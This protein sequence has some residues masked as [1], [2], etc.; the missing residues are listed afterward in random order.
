MVSNSLTN[1]K[2][3]GKELIS[4]IIPIYNSAPF[5]KR[6]INSILLQ[7]FKD[8]ELILV[9]DGSTDNSCDICNEFASLDKRIKVF[10]RKNE[11]AGAARKF[12][13]SQAKGNWIMFCDSDDILPAISIESLYKQHDKADIIVGTLEIIDNKKRIFNHQIDGIVTSK[14][15]IDALLLN[16]TSIGPVGKLFRRDLFSLEIWNDDK[17]IKN[18]EDLLMLIVFSLKAENIFIDNSKICYTYLLRNDS[19]RTN[20]SPV[21]VWYKLFSN[22]ENLLLR[23]FQSAPVSFYL[24][25]LHRL[26]DCAILKGNTVN[27]KHERVQ[28]ILEICTRNELSKY[29]KKL[30]RILQNP[31]KQKIVYQKFKINQKIRRL[32]KSL[33]DEEKISLIR[34]LQ[35]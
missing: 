21:D 9:N 17:D 29:D 34:R 13:V 14:E 30:F 10:H 7:T 25:E 6:C 2:G 11:G 15:Y 27:I 4:V 35:E 26:Y 28:K 12:G 16:K 31:I 18:N 33:L 23:K 5:L 32:V 22:I 20:V 24:Y 3:G 8:F 19:C 1:I